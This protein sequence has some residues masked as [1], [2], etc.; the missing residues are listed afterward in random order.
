MPLLK[1]HA[2]LWRALAIHLNV[3]SKTLDT[4][5]KR[6]K[7]GDVFLYATLPSLGK[8]FEHGLQGR[9][10]M[11]NTSFKK[12]RHS[13][14]PAFLYELFIRVFYKDG[15]IRLDPVG[16]RDIRQLLMMFY[17]FETPLLLKDEEEAN[18][19]FIE[20]DNLVKNKGWPEGLDIVRKHFLSILPNDPF[21][22]KPHHTGGASAIPVSNEFKVHA[23]RKIYPLMDTFG[24]KYFFNSHSHANNWCTVNKTETAN[25]YSRVTHVPKDSRGPRTICMEPHELM[26]IQKGLQTKL[27]DHIENHS[28]AK[29]YINFTDQL[30][31]QRLAY[32]ASIDRRYVTIDLKDASDMV[33]WELVKYLVSPDW[34]KALRAS[35]STHACVGDIVHQLNKFAPM[36]SALCFPIEAMVFWSILRSITTD[37]WVYG[38]DIIVPIELYEQSIEALQS[39]G[40][41]INLNKTLAHGYFRESCGGDYY[42]G[43]NIS[44]IKCKSYDLPSFVPFCNQIAEVYGHCLSDKF[45]S[46]IEDD[47]EPIMRQPLS[48][49]NQPNP[50]VYYTDRISSAAVFFKRRWLKDLQI[51][52]L[53]WQQASLLQDAARVKFLDKSFKKLD[54]DLLFDWFTQSERNVEPQQDYFWNKIISDL[55]LEEPCYTIV[56]KFKE[57]EK[58]VDRKTVHQ[59]VLAGIK[60]TWG[61]DYISQL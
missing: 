15:Y 11:T 41:V 20:R 45:I 29:G 57:I 53:R 56:T 12:Q 25:Q 5:E 52:Q 34:F 26:F 28:P 49:R 48:N 37:V 43:E 32:E 2:A 21:D 8:D 22:I 14:L 44:Y 1:R 9:F 51:Y 42:K 30:I 10:Q 4:F 31:N 33:S 46:V 58:P 50:T 55:P 38:D 3:N 13:E 18:I 23:R 39:Y 16:I 35:R 54:D 40:L 60:Y 59:Q 19:K 24:V 47:G 61:A 6:L 7:Q 27:Y 17:K 36:G